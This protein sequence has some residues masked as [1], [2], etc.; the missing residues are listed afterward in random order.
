MEGERDSRKR[1]ISIFVT[2]IIEVMITG[3]IMSDKLEAN[4]KFQ[5]KENIN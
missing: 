5:L 2:I 3:I 4:E 1:K